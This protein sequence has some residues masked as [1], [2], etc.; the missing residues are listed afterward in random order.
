M[1]SNIITS[2]YIQRALAEDLGPS[3][4]DISADLCV[5]ADMH[6]NLKLNS[7]ASGV[8][9]GLGFVTRTFEMV[10]MTCQV[11]LLAQDGD[12]IEPGQC[13]AT[14]QGP[15]RSLLMAER[16]ALNFIT[17]LSGIA[18][19]TAQ[20]VKAVQGTQ[21]KIMDTRK[22]LPGLRAA[23]KY[24]VT[25]GGGVNHRFGLY[26]AVMIKDNHIA[27]A[28]GIQSALDRVCSKAGHTIKIEVEVDTLDQLDEVLAHGGADIVLLDNMDIPTLG[29]AV[30]RAKG[31]IVTEASGGV[32]LKT[33]RAIA[34][35]GVDYISVGALTHSAP[36]FDIG[37][38][39]A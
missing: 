26:D 28:G 17:H 4:Q 8:I 23:Q 2:E 16:T 32:T 27:L 9:A 31:K 10:D 22:T 12:I 37:L 20:H 15:A 34:E 5:P 39:D 38:D 25:C 13:L 14:V 30:S 29:E 36:Y 3:V 7:R 33:V 24:A 1:L 19:L 18:T 35:T 21:A 11:Q 6:A